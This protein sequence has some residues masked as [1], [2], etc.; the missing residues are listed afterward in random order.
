MSKRMDFPCSVL[1]FF[2][3][4]VPAITA[5]GKTLTALVRRN[6]VTFSLIDIFFYVRRI[7][8]LKRVFFRAFESKA[9]ALLI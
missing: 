5:P 9:S 6:R 8:S 1:T 2:R 4:A 7:A 3:H